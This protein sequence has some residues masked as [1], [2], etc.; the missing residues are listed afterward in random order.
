MSGV[1]AYALH[2][3][4]A[5]NRNSLGAVSEAARLAAELGGQAEVVVVGGDELSDAMCGSLGR[6]GAARVHRAHAPAGVAQPVVDA[7]AHV[8]AAGG[9]RYAF[10]G[11]GLLGFEVGAAL[12]A[13][14]GGGA[15]MEVTAVRVE[16]GRVV[17]ERPALRDTALADVGYLREPGILIGRVNAFETVDRGDVRAAVDDVRVEPSTAAR[18]VRLLRRGEGRGGAEDPSNADIVVAGG[19]GLGSAES[20]QRCAALARALGGAV[21]A[22]RAAVDAGWCGYSAQVGQTGTTV[23]PR[24]YLAAGVSGAVQHRVGMERAQHV[25]A[26]NSDREAPIFEYADLGVV[27][28]A[29]RILPRLTSAVEAARARPG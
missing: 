1:L 9:H 11:G 27:G 15:T 18:G 20:F 10:F 19:R 25:V 3:D 29:N 6:Y 21:A 22:T 7:M 4:G 5:F 13:R 2:H 26:I 14:M 12:A 16:G 23:A 17:A 8:M 28:D 24:L